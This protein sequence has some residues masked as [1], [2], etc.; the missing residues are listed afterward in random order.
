MNQVSQETGLFRFDTTLRDAF[1][2]AHWRLADIPLSILPHNTSPL[3]L[4]AY[5]GIEELVVRVLH[6]DTNINAQDSVGHTPLF[7]GCIEGL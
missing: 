2:K 6:W 5:S 3:H 4:A 7:H 1:F